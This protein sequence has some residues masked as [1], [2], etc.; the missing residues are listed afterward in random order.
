MKRKFSKI[1]RVSVALVMVLALS[2]ALTPVPVMAS[3]SVATVTVTPNSISTAAE[4]SVVFDAYLPLSL[5][6]GSDTTS[7]NATN[8]ALNPALAAGDQILG[9]TFS[10]S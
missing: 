4:Y 3:V 10:V 6:K 1:L 5:D 7:L 8:W 2:V 9:P